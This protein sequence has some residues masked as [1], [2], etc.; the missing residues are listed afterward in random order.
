MK[1]SNS[2]TEQKN[3]N[4]ITMNFSKLRDNSMLTS[5][6]I[7][8]KQEVC[9]DSRGERYDVIQN[10]IIV[11]SLDHLLQQLQHLYQISKEIICCRFHIIRIK[12]SEI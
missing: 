2:E 8:A 5:V 7:P 3:I 11:L 9:A 4:R 1:S 12:I 6:C 10:L